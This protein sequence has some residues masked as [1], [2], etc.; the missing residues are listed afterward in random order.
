M[1]AQQIYMKRKWQNCD[2]TEYFTVQRDIGGCG[3]QRFLQ[4]DRAQQWSG[5]LMQIICIKKN[6]AQTDIRGSGLIKLSVNY[7]FQS[8]HC[9]W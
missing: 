5:E 2:K 7:L 6:K 4:M 9:Q 3:A 1:E 8:Y